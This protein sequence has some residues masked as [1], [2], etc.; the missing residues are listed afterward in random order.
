MN[1]IY[2]IEIQESQSPFPPIKA[3]S[4]NVVGVV[5][6]GSQTPIAFKSG[7][8]SDQSASKVNGYLEDIYRQAICPVVLADFENMKK[9]ESTTKMKPS[10]LVFEK[11]I[12]KAAT[13][14]PGPAPAPNNKKKML[15]GN[16]DLK[17]FQSLCE[18]L[19]AIGVVHLDVS[20]DDASDFTDGENAHK[21]LL[22]VSGTLRQGKDDVT[23]HSTLAGIIAREKFWASPFNKEIL[24]I[25]AI[26]SIEHSWT[27][28]E[29]ES[30]KWSK[31]KIAVPIYSEG[32]F[33]IMGTRL[34]DG[35]FVNVKRIRENIKATIINSHAWAIDEGIT[36]EYFAKVAASVNSYLSE[37]QASKAI[38]GGECI[39]DPKKNTSDSIEEGLAY[40]LYEFTPTYTAEKLVFT[41][42]VTDRFSESV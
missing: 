32:M 28:T 9:A 23:L 12:S 41:E 39:P 19:G 3:A 16:G 21:N 20:L 6:E 25:D 24:D 18:K 7:K 5:L 31:A 1:D 11:K 14:D 36:P 38:A 37:L 10:I 4:S 42:K 35:S 34:A 33:K 2:G 27:D 13:P 26:G 22:Y 30:Q 15:A 8:K 40:W 17:K 29:A